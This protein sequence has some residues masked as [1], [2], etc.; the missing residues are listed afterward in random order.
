MSELFI[1]VLSE[2]I[3]YWLQKNIV[4]QFKTKLHDVIIENQLSGSETFNINFH[5]TP[6][7]LIFFCDNLINEQKSSTEI[8][9]GPAVDAPDTAIEGF[10]KNIGISKKELKKKDFKKKTYYFAKHEKIGRK[11]EDIIKENLEKII[12]SLNWQKSM[13]WAHSSFRWGRPLKNIL[14]YFDS[15]NIPLNFLENYSVDNNPFTISHKKV[16]KELRFKNFNQYKKK[17]LNSKVI[18]E[19]QKREEKIKKEIS[20]F[21]QSKKIL[22]KNEHNNLIS[23]NAGLVE[24]PSILFGKIH[25]DFMSLPQEILEAV[26]IND[27]NFIPLF[28]KNN[29]L[30][31]YFVIVSDYIKKEFY[32]KITEDNEKVLQARFAD[33]SFYWKNDLK[34]K[35]EERLSLLSDI[36]F[37]EKLGSF[38]D[39]EKRIESIAQVLV[40]TLKVKCNST[41]LLLAAKL[42]KLDLTTGLVREFPELQGI[43]GGYIA[44]KQKIKDASKNVYLALKEQ[45]LPKG[46]LD[47][48]PKNDLSYILSLSDKLDTLLGFF[49]IAEIPSASKDPYALRR[50]AL[51]ILRIIIE[52]NLKIKLE[53]FLKEIVHIYNLP[54]ISNF[55]V[56]NLI[57]F[58]TERFKFLLKSITKKQDVVNSFFTHKTYNSNFLILYK[59]FLALNEFIKKGEGKKI[60]ELNK[61]ALNIVT[62]EGKKMHIKNSIDAALLKEK[63]EFILVEKLNQI[64]NIIKFEQENF[65]NI[66]N[67]I[68]SLHLPL[69]NFFDNVM[70]NVNDLKIKSNR[71]SI[72]KKVLDTL[73]TYA[74]FSKI[75]K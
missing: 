43:I 63:Q 64:E 28:N 35:F 12:R 25:K 18:I 20:R 54:N 13:R 29:N 9:K 56:K 62:I 59:K 26:M 57:I 36:Q 11:S 72:L 39:K 4:E 7:R 17:L 6:L 51:G 23:L 8:I 1:E 53:P 73:K 69:N 42:S 66:L 52:N 41:E 19:H 47:L 30:S 21:C 31:S 44:E 22:L 14:F 70:V 37:H 27:Q 34:I 2:E 10:I 60:I 61:R 5:F 68:S 3:P 74:D 65:Q 58:L 24:F 32:K 46:P 75:Q 40:E 15:K 45:Y 71:L 16:D 38:E 48:C 67:E 50:A 49:L 33:A 55:K